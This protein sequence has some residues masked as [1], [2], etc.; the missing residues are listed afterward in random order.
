MTPDRV[1]PR[2]PAALGNE[3]I[4]RSFDAALNQLDNSLVQ[5]GGLVEHQLDEALNALLKRAVDR[6][7]QI[8][9]TDLRVD[10]AEQRIDQDAVALLALR[11]PMAA[12]LRIVISAL[13]TSAML[14][15]IGDYA[16]NVA[17]RTVIIAESPPMPSAIAVARLGRLTQTML[18]DVLDAYATRDVEKADEVRLRDEEVDALY[19]SVFRE[20]LTYMMEDPRNIT[21]CTHLLFVAKNLERVGDHATNIAENVHFIVHGRRPAGDRPKR[22]RTTTSLIETET[23]G[24]G[25]P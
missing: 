25:R 16:K 20:L 17:R 14:E 5:L 10:N 1:P 11:Q 24:L 2:K 13:K 22:D 15:R 12:D 9:A 6:A 21:A 7:A 3:H 18:K 23:G 19:T 8:A 4:V